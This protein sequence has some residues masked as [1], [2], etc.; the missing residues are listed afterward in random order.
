MSTQRISQIPVNCVV[1]DPDMKILSLDADEV[2]VDADNSEG[3][4]TTQTLL[5]AMS[6]L[7]VVLFIIIV[8]LIIRSRRDE[9]PA[10]KAQIINA[11]RR[12]VHHQPPHKSPE[13]TVNKRDDRNVKTAVGKPVTTHSPATVEY[14]SDSDNENVEHS[15]HVDSTSDNIGDETD[16]SVVKREQ[17]EADAPDGNQITA[18]KAKANAEV[19]SIE[20]I[21]NLIK[22]C[23][24]ESSE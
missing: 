9:D 18:E 8:W 6:I 3:F 21:D 4:F 10:V 19:V 14:Y 20:Q 17:K 7:V 22:L 13:H 23:D 2:I 1:S 24:A 16:V 5:I 15:K 12:P 11:A